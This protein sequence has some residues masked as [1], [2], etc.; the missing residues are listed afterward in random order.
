MT[1]SFEDSH[2][3]KFKTLKIESSLGMNVRAGTVN[4]GYSW[5]FLKE[6]QKDSNHLHAAVHHN[7]NLAKETLQ[8]NKFSSNS[9]NYL[10]TIAKNATHV[11]CAIEWGSQTI[12][13]IT[14]SLS[15]KSNPLVQAQRQLK[16]TVESLRTQI[17]K[18]QIAK[19]DPA[20]ADQTILAYS[21]IYRDSIYSSGDFGVQNIYQAS[22]LTRAMPKF[23]QKMNGGKGQPWIYFLIPIE[24]LA[25]VTSISLP[26][27]IQ[28][29]T[30][31]TDHSISSH[32]Y[33]NLAVTLDGL[34]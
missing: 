28:E 22:R 24:T 23:C 1:V 30:P 14:H 16:A 3:A 4:L 25:L 21:G 20:I 26:A 10:N 29:T 13:S 27:H 7:L 18:N 6:T 34:D 15:N 2:A 5:L 11:V 12:F 9:I 19:N 33:D 8:L 17:E 32:D 31:V